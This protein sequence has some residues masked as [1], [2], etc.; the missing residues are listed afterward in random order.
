[1]LQRILVLSLIFLA[2]FLSHDL[3][4]QWITTPL[5]VQGP[6]Q[7]ILDNQVEIQPDHVVLRI[8]NA[9]FAGFTATHSMDPVIDSDSNALEVIPQTEEDIH[10]GDIVSYEYRG[11]ILIH[12]V[13]GK[14][15]DSEGTYYIMK[16]DNV[17]TPDPAKVRFGQIQR[18]LVAILY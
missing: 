9:Q 5:D 12:R 18:V 1:M 7:R 6:H 11:S 4:S 16:G 8:P 15:T 3:Y 13:V 17:N 2:G 14:G 10:I